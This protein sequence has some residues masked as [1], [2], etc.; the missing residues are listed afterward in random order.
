MYLVDASDPHQY[1]LYKK[2]ISGYI[3]QYRGIGVQR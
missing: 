1:V 2:T 3:Y